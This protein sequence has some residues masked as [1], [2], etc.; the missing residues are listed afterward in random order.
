[1]LAPG[2]FLLVTTVLWL[3]ADAFTRWQQCR[4]FYSLTAIPPEHA[5]LH[6]SLSLF[7]EGYG[8]AG[9]NSPDFRGALNDM[10]DIELRCDAEP[11]ALLRPLQHKAWKQRGRAPIVSSCTV[12]DMLRAWNKT[13]RMITTQFVVLDFEYGSTNKVEAITASVDKSWSDFGSLSTGYDFGC[14]ASGHVL[15]RGCRLVRYLAH[16]CPEQ[17][18]ADLIR[19]LDDPRVL[20]WFTFQDTFMYRTPPTRQASYRVGKGEEAAT[21]NLQTELQPHSKVVSLPIGPAGPTSSSGPGVDFFSSNFIE[22][23]LGKLKEVAPDR[24]KGSL[25]RPRLLIET[26]SDLGIRSAIRQQIS[27]LHTNASIANSEVARLKHNL[28]SPSART[29]S[30]REAPYLIGPDAFCLQ[31]WKS[32]HT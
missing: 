5:L 16:Y 21:I 23:A 13:E 3:T 14:K 22:L 2:S 29:R 27:R 11:G 26:H 20:A 15:A 12:C 10:V 7:C 9:L 17:R 28:W 6:A 8:V 19:F 1:M 25:A 24:R 4:R 30:G 18:L 32:T 31:I